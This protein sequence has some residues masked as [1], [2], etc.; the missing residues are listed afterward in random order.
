MAPSFEP[1]MVLPPLGPN[2]LERYEAFVIDEYK[3]ETRRQSLVTSPGD[4][5]EF[6]A[7]WAMKEQCR[8]DRSDWM[9]DSDDSS[10]RRKRRERRKNGMRRSRRSRL[11]CIAS[12]FKEEKTGWGGGGLVPRARQ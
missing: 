3:E 12:A 6:M 11:N 5:T 1:G 10:D 7:Y 8:R 9:L 4:A 2:Y